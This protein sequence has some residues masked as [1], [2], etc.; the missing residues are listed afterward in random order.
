MKS[1]TTLALV[2][3]LPSTFAASLTA[4]NKC[5]FSIYVKPDAQGFSGAVSEI[6]SGATWTGPFETQK[7]GNAVKFSKSSTDFSRPIS[8]DYS[9]S[10]S[11]T[12]YDVSDA[13]GSPF[14]LVARDTTGGGQTC[15]EV[16]CPNGQCKAV[17][18]CDSSHVYA[19]QAC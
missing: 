7:F 2:A 5:S 9:V 1:F 19:I 8:F 13:A 6:K 15:P 11:L 4:T 14:P 17:K 10:G 12:Y 18:A 16:G 3:L